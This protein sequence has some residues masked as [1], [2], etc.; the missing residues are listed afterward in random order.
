MKK[1]INRGKNV[2]G[3]GEASEMCLSFMFCFPSSN[4]S[5]ILV[6]CLH[7]KCKIFKRCIKSYSTKC[8]TLSGLFISTNDSVITSPGADI[9]GFF[10]THI[11]A[12]TI[13]KKTPL[14]YVFNHKTS[15]DDGCASQNNLLF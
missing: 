12:S 14:K 11:S 4:R 6:A 5:I 2:T 7:H 9:S 1:E 15:S 10:K 8:L 3:S 13:I